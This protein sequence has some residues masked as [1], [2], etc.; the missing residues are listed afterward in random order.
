MAEPVTS[1]GPGVWKG[2]TDRART[3]FEA[4]PGR[5]GLRTR[6]PFQGDASRPN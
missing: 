6:K 3:F 4:R 2:G 1:L 5:K